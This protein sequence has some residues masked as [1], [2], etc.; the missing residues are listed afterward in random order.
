MNIV[1]LV[2]ILLFLCFWNTK[3]FLSDFFLYKF[4]VSIWNFRNRLLLWIVLVW[5]NIDAVAVRLGFTIRI[6]HVKLILRIFI[7]LSVILWT[8]KCAVI[9]VLCLFHVFWTQ[10][11]STLIL[12]RN[13]RWVY[14]YMMWIVFCTALNRLLYFLSS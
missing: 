8:L 4:C 13:Y 9:I 5:L 7:G 3:L 11:C 6:E 10:I 2:T 14:I 1:W 12:V